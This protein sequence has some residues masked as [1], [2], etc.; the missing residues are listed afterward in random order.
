MA[1]PFPSQDLRSK[2]FNTIAN[3]IIQYPFDEMSP[4]CPAAAQAPRQR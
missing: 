1:L 2:P 4:E 3:N